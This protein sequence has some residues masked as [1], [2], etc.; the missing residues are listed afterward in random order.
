M[1]G[2]LQLIAAMREAGEQ[3]SV[4]TLLCDSGNRYGDTYYD[5]PWLQAQGI[6]IAPYAELLDVFT[7]SGD[8]PATPLLAAAA[9]PAP[10]ASGLPGSPGKPHCPRVASHGQ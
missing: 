7:R 5:D 2:A 9:P 1:W 6:D 3:G 10:P 4:G 8:W